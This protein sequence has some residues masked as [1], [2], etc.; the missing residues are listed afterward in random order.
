MVLRPGSGFP[1]PRRG[2][3]V[4]ALRVGGL[5]APV[6]AR[7]VFSADLGDDLVL[8]ARALRG[9]ISRAPGDLSAK[10]ATLNISTPSVLRLATVPSP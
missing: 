3:D 5:R 1:L 6:A 9:F 2:P 4:A 7:R 8:R 10:A